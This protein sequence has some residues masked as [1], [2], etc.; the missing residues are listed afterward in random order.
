MRVE[1]ILQFP[2]GL[3]V[4]SLPAPDRLRVAEG[5]AEFASDCAAEDRGLASG[6][7]RVRDYLL[8]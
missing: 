6:L 8:N 1:N 4:R 3:S 7:D 2:E 5:V